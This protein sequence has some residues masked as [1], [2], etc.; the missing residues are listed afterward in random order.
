L[1]VVYLIYIVQSVGYKQILGED[2]AEAEVD[3]IMKAVDS[4]NSGALDYTGKC[5]IIFVNGLRVCHGDY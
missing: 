1:Q 4:N 5:R 2:N 3:R